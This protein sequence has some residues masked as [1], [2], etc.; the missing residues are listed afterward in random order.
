[1]LSGLL[2][3]RLLKKQLQNM[4]HMTPVVGR[5][6]SMPIRVR[7]RMRQ[8]LLSFGQWLENSWVLAA[9][10]AKSKALGKFNS[11]GLR[12]P[13]ANIHVAFGTSGHVHISVEP[14]HEHWLCSRNPVKLPGTP[15]KG[16]P[17]LPEQRVAPAS[18]H[19]P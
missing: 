16:I 17:M 13:T 15:Q 9:M 7:T 14:L 6:P 5:S 3:L 11:L 10:S 19:Q 12:Y 18:R 8:A 4:L 2:Q 1:M